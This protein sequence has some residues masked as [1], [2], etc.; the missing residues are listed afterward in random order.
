M[1]LGTQVRKRQGFFAIKEVAEM[2]GVPQPRFRNWLWAGYVPRPRTRFAGGKRLYYVP[3]D[4]E[5]I[6]RLV[7]K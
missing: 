3:T 2:L 1:R 7:A 4:V 6:K 5:E